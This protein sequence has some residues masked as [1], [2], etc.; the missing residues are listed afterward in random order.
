MSHLFWYPGYELPLKHITRAE[1]CYLYAAD[2]Q[3]YVD[4]ESGVWC[5]AI[6]HSHPAVLEAL[7]RQAAQ[8]S[9]TGYAYSNS[10]LEEVA[11]AV[12]ELHG[13]AEGKCNFLCSG[14]EAVEF[15]VRVAQTVK[16]RP[17]L[18]T[19]S[20]SYFGA[21]G[22]A[23]QQAADEWY[24]FDWQACAACETEGNCNAECS[25]WAAIPFEYLGGFLFEP[26]S[27]SGLVRFPPQK[28]IRSIAA[29]VKA[30]D[31]LVLINEVTTGM[32]RTGK[33]FGYQH[34]ELAPDSVVM[35]KGIGN[36][37]P[38]SVAAF[39]PG[40]VKRLG[41][42]PVLDAQSHQNDPLGAA[43]ARAVIDII[44]AEGLIER[45]RQ[46]GALLKSGLK[47]VQARTGK[48]GAIRARGLMVAVEL[49]D[50]S[51]LDFTTRV[52]AQLLRAGFIVAQ[53]PDLNVLR[54][55]P[56]LTIGERDITEFLETFEAVLSEKTDGGKDGNG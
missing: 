10:I 34:Y 56:P 23:R 45:G 2:G 51:P 39:S 13:F 8:I 33:W 11:R 50:A 43:V 49:A 53:R 14:S 35:G 31:G 19:L 26:G 38:V 17:L 46:M 25:R 42:R 22:A 4:L 7:A 9:H 20:D 48:I 24:A 3:R 21:Y 5:T 54:I 16:P 52:Q 47:G 29:A 41:D 18:L 40:L 12:L 36:G 44:T 55:D 1:N 6:G 32:G 27:S 28:L 30:N 15:S 37:Y